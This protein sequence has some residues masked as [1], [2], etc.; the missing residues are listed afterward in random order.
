[1][2]RDNEHSNSQGVSTGQH[3]SKGDG[4]LRFLKR[5]NLPVNR[6]NYLA[7]HYMDP[8]ITPDTDLGAELEMALP[9]SVR[10]K[11]HK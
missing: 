5:L 7:L 2:P 11:N 4:T 6:A 10:H 3:G 1:M 8:K 9:P